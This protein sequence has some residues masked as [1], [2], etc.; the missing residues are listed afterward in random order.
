VPGGERQ[1][2]G[3]P[4]GAWLDN[5]LVIDA[6]PDPLQG[7][8]IVALG[9]L[10]ED[11]GWVMCGVAAT[12]AHDSGFTEPARALARHPAREPRRG[13]AL[14]RVNEASGT[15]LSWRHATQ[16]RRGPSNRP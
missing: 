9:D 11:L 6:G 7:M 12:V 10:P 14:P 8:V 13:F 5:G 16:T 15:A 2:T 1:G 3:I 4:G